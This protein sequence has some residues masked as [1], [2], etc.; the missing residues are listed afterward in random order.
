MTPLAEYPDPHV[1][2]D[3]YSHKRTLYKAH[4]LSGLLAN[5]ELHLTPER[6]A[7]LAEK[8]AEAAMGY[9]R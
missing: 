8:H 7:A 1:T 4:A 5:Q 2:A 6:A 9:E 3:S